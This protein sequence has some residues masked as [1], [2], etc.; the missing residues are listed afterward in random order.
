M[1]TLFPRLLLSNGTVNVDAFCSPYCTVSAKIPRGEVSCSQFLSSTV[2]RR[3]TAVTLVQLI[4]C[5]F[6]YYYYFICG[7][8][9]GAAS[10]SA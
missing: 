3:P 5:C 6:I 2:I 8:F 4:L 10:I 9:D 1:V 7:L